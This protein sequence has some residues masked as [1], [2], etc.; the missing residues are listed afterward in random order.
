M[1]VEARERSEAMFRTQRLL[2]VGALAACCWSF[3]PPAN[4][5]TT[6]RVSVDSAGAQAEGSSDFQSLSADG[7]FVA[8]ESVA[9]NLVPGDTKGFV[10]VFVRD[11]LSSTTEHVSVDS[12]G[13]Q[14]EGNSELPSISAD[15]RFVAFRSF[16]TNLV[17]GDTNGVADIFVRDR[18]AGTTERVSVDSAEAQASSYNYENSISAE[19]RFVAFLSYAPN[20]VPGDT[21]G[22]PDIFVR[23]RVTGMTERVSVSSAEA[24]AD[25]RSYSPSIS[26]DGRFAGFYSAATNLVPGDTNG[27]FDVF[28]RDRLTGTTERVSV[29]SADAQA[30]NHSYGLSISADDRFVAF[31]SEATN[32]VPGDTNGAVD[33]FVHNRHERDDLLVDLASAGLWQWLNNTNW[34]RIHA[35]SPLSVA[36]GDLNGNFTDEAI[37]SFNGKGLWVHYSTPRWLKLHDTVPTHFVTG[38]L[39]GNG[40]DEVIADFGAS[41]AGGLWI[42]WNNTT[43]LKLTNWISED[44]AVGD[45]DGDGKKDLVAD[46]GTHGLW[47]WFNATSWT[48]LYRTSPNHIATGDLD[49]NRQD[50]LIA[51]LDTRG[52]F[53]RYNNA[54]PWVKLSPWSSEDLA[55][56]DLDG[57]GKDELIADFGLSHGLYAR[58]DTGP[59]KKLHPRSPFKIVATDLDRNGQDDL[60]AAFGGGLYVRY[61]NTAAWVKRHDPPIQDIAAGGLD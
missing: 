12:A 25:G 13:A 3:C 15:G 2:L 50:D 30:N 39:D 41:N 11:R 16:A 52:L 35:G 60:I 37:V 23:D 26:A 14:P 5:G 48:A 46:F 57:N 9:A 24:Q 19:G 8:F 28:V 59:W 42:F 51:D 27:S 45:L 58:F 36:T 61:N 43:W 10:N 22:A 47:A 44:L 17:P 21:N 38:D 32:L 18:L 55:T 20:L 6:E 56:G 54:T 53:A 4:A 31:Y 33:V 40:S 1:P 7:R 49:G 34:V 29:S